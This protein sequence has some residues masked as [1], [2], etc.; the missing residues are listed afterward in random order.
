METIIPMTG[1]RSIIA[2]KMHASLQNMAQ[3][4]FHEE[5]DA[6]A[7]AAFCQAAKESGSK[8]SYEDIIVK[9]VSDTLT[10]HPRFNGQLIDKEIRLN[11]QH[12]IC[13]AVALKEGLVAPALYAVQDKSIA[14]V[15]KARKALI[16]RCRDN[17]LTVEEMTSGTF[18]ISNLGL[19]RIHYFTPVI[20]AP[21]MAILGVGRVTRRAWVDGSDKVSVRPVLGLSLT[22]D[23]RAIDGDDAGAFLSALVERL[24]GLQCSD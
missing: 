17:R 4:S 18:T 3:L 16:Q 9:L 7:L 21:Q 8:V 14:E 24:E 19:R 23:H 15:A 11:D 5:L 20:N 12:N 1:M 2:S 6:S 10:E 13:V 22:V